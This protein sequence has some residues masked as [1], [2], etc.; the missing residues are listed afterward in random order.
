MKVKHLLEILSKLD[1][2]LDV[3]V[4]H[5]NGILLAE[6]AGVYEGL[7]NEQFGNKMIYHKTW[8]QY[9]LIG[10][11]GNFDEQGYHDINKPI[12][13]FDVCENDVILKTI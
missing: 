5:D 8:K 12:T 2:E 7:L 6:E 9:V 10:N 1:K 4:L 11:P 13:T 3:G